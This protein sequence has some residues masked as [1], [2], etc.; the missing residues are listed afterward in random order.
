MSQARSLEDAEKVLAEVRG[1][2]WKFKIVGVER[3]HLKAFFLLRDMNTAFFVGESKRSRRN[4]GYVTAC[5]ERANTGLIFFRIA[6]VGPSL[7]SP[8]PYRN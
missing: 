5:K 2:Q 4:K 3:S 7:S 8:S 1:A 6:A